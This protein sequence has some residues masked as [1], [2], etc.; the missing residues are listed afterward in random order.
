MLVALR[1]W[2]LY[3]SITV[4]PSYTAKPRLPLGRVMPP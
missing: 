4:V 1:E 3:L 2:K